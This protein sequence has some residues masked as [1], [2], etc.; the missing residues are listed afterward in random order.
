[1]NLAI[2]WAIPSYPPQHCEQP[3]HL[4]LVSG[5]FGDSPLFLK[6]TREPKPILEQIL[7]QPFE[8]EIWRFAFCSEPPTS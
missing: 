6:P 8:P 5:S 7:E 3:P 1:M 4:I 2:L